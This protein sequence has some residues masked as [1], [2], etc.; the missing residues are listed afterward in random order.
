[1]AKTRILIGFPT[2]RYANRKPSGALEIGV[3]VF[4]GLMLDNGTMVILV[5]VLS[6]LGET[7]KIR[8]LHRLKITVHRCWRPETIEIFSR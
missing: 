2:K 1:M 7:A 6:V 8:D 4:L 5:G 3:P